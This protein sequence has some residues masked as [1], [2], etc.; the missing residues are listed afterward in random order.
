MINE[1]IGKIQRVLLPT[2]FALGLV[3]AAVV[4][5]TGVIRLEAYINPT[6]PKEKQGLVQTLAQITGGTA[7]LVGLY[8][9]R[10]TVQLNQE[11][12]ITE[13]F[14]KAIDQLGA[15]EGKDKRLEIRL[16]GIYALGRIA[17]DSEKDYEPIIEV[18]AAYVREH[19]PYPPKE[20]SPVYNKTNMAS[21]IQAVLNVVG[22]PTRHKWK[23][24]HRRI[25]LSGTD[26]RFGNLSGIRLEEADLHGAHLGLADLPK[27]HLKGTD[28]YGAHLEEANLQGA[29]LDEAK[30]SVA[31]LEGADLRGAHLKGTDFYG[32]HLEGA[33]LQGAHLDEASLYEAHLEGT[34]LRGVDLRSLA[35]PQLIKQ[36]QIQRA[37]GDDNTKLPKGLHIPPW[38]EQGLPEAGYLALREYCTEVFK[39]ALS[40]RITDPQSGWHHN[41]SYH[42]HHPGCLTIQD[43]SKIDSPFELRRLSFLSPQGVFAQKNPTLDT[44]LPVPDDLVKWFRQHR[45]LDTEQPVDAPPIGG[46]CGTQFDAVVKSVPDEYP[47]GCFL[48][49]VILLYLGYGYRN[50][51]RFLKGY[52]YR[53]IILH[54]G[55]HRVTIII[56]SPAE[57]FED[58]LPKATDLLNTVEWGE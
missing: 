37:I 15:G 32:A 53:T 7:L 14:T 57:D 40:F 12:Q 20:D 25:Y 52:K 9:T 10:R 54:A 3:L 45:S 13:R 36:E 11:G 5:V 48:P 56:E 49:C 29:H 6:T 51:Y 42:Q 19:A 55:D 1:A 30:L 23:M 58:F 50:H 44:F 18:L 16:G 4:L 27:A 8:F 39:P 24:E 34:D 33:N 17:R 21:D 38:W 2:A 31:H 47:T 46:V 26:L 35:D 41:S 28:F 43:Y 22:R